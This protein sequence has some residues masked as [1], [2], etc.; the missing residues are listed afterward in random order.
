M[1]QVYNKYTIY[2]YIIFNKFY[3]V[4]VYI[5][6][7]N[8]KKKKKIDLIHVLTAMKKSVPTL[9]SNNFKKHFIEI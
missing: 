5:T 6:I 1:L 2:I 9:M 3:Q 4:F 8:T 7:H